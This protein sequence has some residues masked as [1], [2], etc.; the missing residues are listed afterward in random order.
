MFRS[1]TFTTKMSTCEFI[2]CLA[3]MRI[4]SGEEEWEKKHADNW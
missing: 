2:L 1:Q 4:S 3:L